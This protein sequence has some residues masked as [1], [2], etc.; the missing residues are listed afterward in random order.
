M[1]YLVLVIALFCGTTCYGQV[2]RPCG[3]PQNRFVPQGWKD[4]DFRPACVKHDKY[5]HN[6]TIS[7]KEADLI[8]LRDM[9]A[10][11]D[12][13]SQPIRA[14]IIARNMY[15]AV[16]LFGRRA[17]LRGIDNPKEEACQNTLNNCGNAPNAV[18]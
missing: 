13:S 5:Y 3:G 17:F 14:K 6:P 15:R 9:L 12:L 1:K 2:W 16:R 10:E 7:R 8:F 4:A 11:C 18:E